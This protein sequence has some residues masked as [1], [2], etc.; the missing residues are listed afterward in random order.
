MPAFMLLS[1]ST[2]QFRR[3]WATE[4]SAIRN[5]VDTALDVV[6]GHYP[7]WP[8]EDILTEDVQIPALREQLKACQVW[9]NDTFAGRFVPMTAATITANTLNW[10]AEHT[11]RLTAE[12]QEEEVSDL[13]DRIGRAQECGNALH[14]ILHA[15][16]V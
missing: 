6:E 3:Q 9:I 16:K 15:P 13:H 5:F 1:V 12:W 4:M 8:D 11:N 7:N 14:R 2:R 10:F